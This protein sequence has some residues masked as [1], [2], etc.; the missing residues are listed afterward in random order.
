MILEE[1]MKTTLAHQRF[2]KTEFAS[3]RDWADHPAAVYTCPTCKTTAEVTRGQLDS[4]YDRRNS[5]ESQQLIAVLREACIWVWRD[6]IHVVHQFSCAG[7]GHHVLVG[8][9]VGEFPLPG[10][11]YRLSMVGES[12]NSP[13]THTTT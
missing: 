7:C 11:V 10:R 9:E 3:K 4:V 1:A 6:S 13:S 8:V 2:S 5:S 12:E